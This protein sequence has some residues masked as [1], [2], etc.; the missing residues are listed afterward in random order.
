MDRR[1]ALPAGA[2]LLHPAAR[3]G[4]AAA[5][6]LYRLADASAP[7]AGWSRARCS[8]CR[9]ARHHGAVSWIYVLFGKV[10]VV[11]GAVLRPEGR[12]A[13]DRGRSRA[14]RRQA[15]PQEQHH[16]WRWRRPRFIAL[17]FYDVPFPIIIFGRRPDRLLGGRAGLPAFL[18]GGGHG[19]VGD[20]Q[21]AD[22]DSLLGE[23]TPEHARPNL[24]WSLSIAG[25]VPGALA[26][27]GRRCSTVVPGRRQR[28]H[29][30]LDLLQQDGGGHLRRRL[31]GAGLC[32]PSRRSSTITG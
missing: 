3:P 9:A 20:K 7:R 12:R 22:A 25:A 32:R 14:A 6:D 29:A 2:Q 19:K 16:A 23:E 18:A 10:T 24:R 21:V 4:G 13:G 27:A 17:F 5:R 30:D 15:G 1:E 8:C 31:C 11:R 28:L 26:G